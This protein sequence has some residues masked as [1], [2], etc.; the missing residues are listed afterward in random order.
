MEALG[1]IV[2]AAAYA[3]YAVF[4][5]RV[6]VHAR[7]WLRAAPSPPEPAATTA[8]ALL[9]AG[10]D[11]LLLGRLLRANPALWIGEWIFH[12]SL[13][14][15]FLRHLRYALEPVPAV[16]R[17]AQ[18]PGLVAG[19]LLPFALAS[20]LA[21]RLLARRESYTSRPNL[22]LLALALAAGASGVALHA[23][24]RADLPAVKGFIL[25]ILGLSPQALPASPLFALHFLLGLAL[26][27]LLPTH[28]L[29][30][31]F[32]MLDARRREAALPRVLHER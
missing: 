12:A 8:K 6:A 27:P 3:A 21:M 17:W 13:L 22:L 32:V 31:P 7:V 23:R 29:T 18:T 30:A 19:Y 24:W 14:L 26:L 20:I 11:A 10:A 15:A 25:G 5:L 2:V 28:V 9:L 16:V 1:P 4:W